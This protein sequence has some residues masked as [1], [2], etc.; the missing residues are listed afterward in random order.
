MN[1][2]LFGFLAFFL[3][4][5]CSRDQHQILKIIDP[6][7]NNY[8]LYIIPMD[9]K[10]AASNVA[11]GNS[12]ITKPILI[13][14]PAT[15][16]AMRREWVLNE[17]TVPKEKNIRYHL[18]IMEDTKK[19]FSAWLDETFNVMVWDK[20][21]LTFHDSLLFKYKDSFTYLP[22]CEVVVKD[23]HDAR[24]LRKEIIAAGG[25]VTNEPRNNR[26]WKKFDGKYVL[27]RD[28]GDLKPSRRIGKLREKIKTDFPYENFMLL[29]FEFDTDSDSMTVWIAADSSYIQ[30][31]PDEYRVS[32]YFDRLRDIRFTSIGPDSSRI[33]EIARQNNMEQIEVSD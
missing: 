12:I 17:R 11:A 6:H 29:D 16:G 5:H 9:Q 20:Y 33:R 28:R 31:I 8:R 30:S 15:L 10:D 3:M 24:T 7:H 4:L 23:I 27:R 1:K 13:D 26:Y 2:I 19:V 22:K 21:L 25:I 14:E 32:G 18:F